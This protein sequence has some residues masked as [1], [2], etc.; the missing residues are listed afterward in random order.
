MWCS[1]RLTTSRGYTLVW[2]SVPWTLLALLLDGEAT[3]YELAK[4]FD[5]SVANFWHALPQQL[6]A[7]LGRMEQDGLVEG[8]VVVQKAR[9]NK[10]I[11]SMTEAGQ[12]ALSAWFDEPARMGA[13][14]NELLVR[15]Y[16]A[17]LADPRQIISILERNIGPHEEKLA[18]YES[19]REL[20]FRGRTEEQ[21]VRTTRRIGPYL[22]LKNGIANEHASLA[23][24]RWAIEAVGARIRLGAASRPRG[25]PVKKR[26]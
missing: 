17:D 12:R 10:R 20:M 26:T 4:R 23:W 15:I 24:A 7:E 9:P 5:R 22:A 11:F 2:L 6:Y 3:G 21:F 19:L 18:L 8:E 13:V 14:K 25:A 1:A 16:A